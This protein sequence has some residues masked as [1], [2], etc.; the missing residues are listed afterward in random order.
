MP[1]ICTDCGHTARPGPHRRAMVRVVDEI[2]ATLLC[3]P[4]LA[5]LVL[6]APAGLNLSVLLSR[7]PVTT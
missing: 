4:C 2:E 1:D 7:A 6:R 3:G 5:V